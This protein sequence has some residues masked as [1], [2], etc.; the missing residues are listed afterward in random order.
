MIEENAGSLPAD[1][2]ADADEK[3]PSFIRF[4]AML[5][6][7]YTEGAACLSVAGLGRSRLCRFRPVRYSRHGVSKTMLACRHVHPIV[8]VHDHDPQIQHTKNLR[9]RMSQELETISVPNAL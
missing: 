3:S 8:E 4:N 2:D 7:C 6:L 9:S 1:G 5:A